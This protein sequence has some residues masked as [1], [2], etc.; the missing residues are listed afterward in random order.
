LPVH[1]AVSEAHL[2]RI[3][4]SNY[5]GY[6]T[7][8][9]FALDPRWGHAHGQPH[10]AH[11]DPSA[12]NAQF[13]AMVQALH[14]AELEVVLDVV[15]NHTA[16]GNELGPTISF[17]G[18]DNASWYRLLP[19]DLA[20]SENFSG[21][22]NTLN[23]AHPRVTQFVL[24]SLRYWVTEMGVDG[25]RFD[26][27]TVLGRT[28]EGFDPNA[29]FFVALRQDPV[30]SQVRL[31]SE[32]WDCGP[33]GYQVGRFPGR[34]IDWNDRF[35]DSMRRYWLGH[36]LTRGEFAR[37]FCGSSD[38]FHHGHKQPH[39]SVNF[40]SAHDGFTLHDLVSYSGKHNQA[41]GEQNRDGRGD[42]LCAN[43]CTEGDTA[44]ADTL[45]VRRRVRHALLASLLLAQGTPMLL[46]GD[47]IGNSQ[48]GNN[49]AYCQDNAIGW[50]NWG[51]KVSET[52]ALVTQL[53]QLRASQPLLRHPSWFVSASASA[54]A[55]RVCWR[56]AGGAEMAVHDWHDVQ[57]SCLACE[58]FA[59]N[60]MRS[61][62]Q[63]L[64]NPESNAVE[65]RLLEGRWQLLFDSSAQASNA[66]V[67]DSA[68]ITQ[69]H[70]APARSL[71]VLVRAHD[72]LA[73]FYPPTEVGAS[74]LS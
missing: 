6:N 1:Y 69:R 34:F 19:D 64:F 4:L 58:Y 27:A 72:A 22:G 2:A 55:A 37:R 7:L 68:T 59:P 30:L 26:L 3:G 56:A 49:N 46:A 11:S 50:L 20:H 16:E 71:S 45:E 65:F 36:E 74:G 70:L 18:L 24:D 61:H 13:R 29:A 38:L 53:L 73:C 40:I 39:A 66:F 32:P 17:R 10:A 47:E 54:G 57:E 60:A 12:L 33:G 23:V 67:T 62:L 25:F 52:Q 41:N 15:F 31:I 9:F 63:L 28:R 42:E 21:C 48:A 35:R 51:S 44:D 14:A 43:F 8:G 5:W